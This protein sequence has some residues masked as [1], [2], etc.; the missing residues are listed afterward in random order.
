M[1]ANTPTPK[2]TTSRLPLPIARK[3]H[4]GADREA[5]SLVDEFLA[6]QRPV[7]RVS[8]TDEAKQQLLTAIETQPFTTAKEAHGWMRTQLG[9]HVTYQTVWRF[10][11]AKGLLVGG[12][13]HS[14]RLEQRT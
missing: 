14:R 1:S 5:C 4:S 9:I 3:S 8:F 6:V 2:R 7:S 13:L 11:N 10:L 12:T